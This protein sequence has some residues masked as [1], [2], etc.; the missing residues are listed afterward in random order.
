MSD[1]NPRVD[2]FIARAGQWQAEFTELRRI[3]LDSGL[4]EELKW[5]VPC[6]TCEKSN[7]VLIHGFKDYCAMLFVKGALLR[8]PR[9]VLIT[10]T[11]NVQAARQVR[12]TNLAEI[13]ALEPVLKDYLAEAI[14]VEKSG[15]AVNYKKTAEF[16]MPDEFQARLD[17][18]PAL[19]SAF[20]AL[21]PG[22]QRAYLLY[23]SAPKQS[24]TRAA[25]V[26]KCIPQILA[27]KGLND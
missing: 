26:A 19:Q 16:S 25:R 8:D 4:N 23:F 1:P 9:G 12:F 13:L 10:Q 3:A 17:E 7:V 14:A 18:L 20:A 27:G 5:G 11:A 2:G 6:Y 22:R 21:T 24:G 15:L